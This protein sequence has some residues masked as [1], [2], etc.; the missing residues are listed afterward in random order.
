VQTRF[1]VYNSPSRLLLARTFIP[2][3][4]P[5]F[6]SA[7]FFVQQ[8]S[9]S[10]GD[11]VRLSTFASS[12]CFSSWIRGSSS[13]CHFGSPCTRYV[14][15]PTHP[16]TSG[17]D[18]P[19][20]VLLRSTARA[21]NYTNTIPLP[22]VTNQLCF[23]IR[24]FVHVPKKTQRTVLSQSVLLFIRSNPV[25]LWTG[26]LRSAWMYSRRAGAP[27]PRRGGCGVGGRWNSR[28]N[29]RLGKWTGVGPCVIGITVIRKSITNSFSGTCVEPWPRSRP[30]H[31]TTPRPGERP[32][33]GTG[34]T[35]RVY[36]FARTVERE[37]M[38]NGRN[39]ARLRG[40]VTVFALKRVV[41]NRESFHTLQV[42]SPIRIDKK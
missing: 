29:A 38:G 40:M 28:P 20:E 39:T 30:R 4:I 11:P 10:C 25:S 16:L 12:F 33:P 24:R 37:N 27:A 13:R 6:T 34:D 8:A 17:T 9:L 19:R 1:P 36:E 7:T 35:E 32:P 3:T 42:Y 15:N 21:R 31:S 41:A 2:H 14:P 18:Y 26:R 23:L 5:V 22:P